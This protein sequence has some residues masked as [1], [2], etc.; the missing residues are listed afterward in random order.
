MGKS[1]SRLALLK[2]FMDTGIVTKVSVEGQV[3]YMVRLLGEDCWDGKPRKLLF[4]KHGALVNAQ[5][6]V[7]IADECL[8]N[9]ACRIAGDFE[10]FAQVNEFGEVYDKA[11]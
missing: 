10:M 7:E 3:R 6:D 4:D 9:A 5:M 2:L 8:K 1:M 11:N